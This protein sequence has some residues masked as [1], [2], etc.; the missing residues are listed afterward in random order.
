MKNVDRWVRCG[1]LISVG[2]FVLWLLWKPVRSVASGPSGTTNPV[3]LINQPLV[4]DAVA[5]GGA[6]FTLTVNGTGFVSGAVVTWNGSLL[7][8][9]FVS[10]SQVTATVSG[11]RIATAGAV[12]VAVENPRPGGGV[13]NV[14]FFSVANPLSRT[15]LVGSGGGNVGPNPVDIVGGD[16]NKDGKADLAFLNSN[17]GTPCR[18]G[19]VTVLLGNGD[20]TFQP[21]VSYPTDRGPAHMVVGDFNNDGNLDLAISNKDYDAVT[22]LLGNGDGT[23]GAPTDSSVV[24]TE[25]VVTA[26]DFNGDGKLDLALLTTETT[27]EVLLGNGNGTFQSPVSYA[28]PPGP[29]SVAVGDFNGDGY[30]DLVVPVAQ[31]ISVFPGNG[32]GTFQ[33]AVVSNYNFV[34][35]PVV[36]AADFNGDG[37]LDLAIGGGAGI[38]VLLGNGDGTFAPPNFYQTGNATSVV[39][40]DFNAD[41]KLDLAQ[42]GVNFNFVQILNGNGDGTFQSSV[43]PSAVCP[44][45]LATGDFENDGLLDLA[46]VGRL[47]YGTYTEITTPL[48]SI[49]PTSLTFSTPQIVGTASPAQMLFLTNTGSQP[50]SLSSLTFTGNGAAN[51]QNTTTCGRTVAAGAQCTF[52]IY[53][54]PVQPGAHTANF[55]IM[56]DAPDSP[57]MFPVSGTGTIVSLSPTSLSFGSEPVGMTS[58]AQTVTVT[59]VSLTA[60][61][62]ISQIAIPGPVNFA[63][64]NTCGVSLPPQS[65]CTIS[66]TFTPLSK[67]GKLASLWIF[68]NGGASPQAVTLSGTGT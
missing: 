20:G 52:S 38:N 58:A 17:C 8:T 51:F 61:L 43:A 16:F 66:V 45:A 55:T 67:G 34:S 56:D 49:F 28:T 63:E 65:S 12:S 2:V 68:D 29:S 53:F 39:T 32:D 33:S 46:Y 44:V 48:V 5:P 25:G 13:S 3:P 30:L 24:E 60:A 42:V 64:T 35:G 27:I 21:G 6:G 18:Q 1:V 59:N 31:G 62:T 15:V 14:A 57:Q 4:P 19:S 47:E 26:G 40:G 50:L 41:G 36:I 54:R 9:T 7:P 23:F 10:G 22:V 37:K 11:G